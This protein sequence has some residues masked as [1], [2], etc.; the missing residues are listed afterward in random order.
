MM[1]SDLHRLI[2]TAH[3]I[4]NPPSPKQ[5][6]DAQS[7]NGT[8][9][10]LLDKILSIITDRPLDLKSDDIINDATYGNII[11]YADLLTSLYH[12]VLQLNG[13]L[14]QVLRA[15]P[16]QENRL[17]TT[18]ILQQFRE[19]AV[20]LD[21]VGILRLTEMTKQAKRGAFL[22]RKI[23]QQQQE[24][25]R[26]IATIRSQRWVSKQAGRTIY[27]HLPSLRD[28]MYEIS[29]TQKWLL[30][31]AENLTTVFRGHEAEFAMLHEE[32]AMAFEGSMWDEW[33]AWKERVI[34]SRWS[35][36]DSQ[37]HPGGGESFCLLAVWTRRGFDVGQ[38]E[39]L[40]W[41]KGDAALVSM[42]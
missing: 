18:R 1:D 5:Y 37:E 20:F 26:D 41:W 19:V 27:H 16:A 34:W 25:N 2:Y 9:S 33:V 39:D 31:E 29:L 10:Y 22:H 40:V 7:T 21:E 38:G 28:V 15:S 12:M 42:W 6:S 4:A 3:T 13:F 8:A 36:N 11:P 17:S 23:Q 30:A 24:L 32:P 35:L 14:G